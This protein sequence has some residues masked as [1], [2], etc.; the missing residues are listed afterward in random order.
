M[1]SKERTRREPQERAVRTRA[2]ILRA[3]AEVFDEFGFSGASISK[4][5]KRAG[6]TQGAMYFHFGSK[7]ELAHAVMIGQG[8]GLHMPEG[9]DGLQRLI[10]ITLYLARQ[11]QTNPVLRGG[12]RLAVEQGEFGMHDDQP[13]QQ[14]VEV[15]RQQLQAARARG[16]LNEAADE[17]ELAVVLVGSFSGTQL[18]SQI[19]TGRAD[20]PELICTLWRY[21]LPAAATEEARASFRIAPDAADV[22]DAPDALPLSD[23]ATP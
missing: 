20:L 3:A 9:E 19:T 17:G 22:P 4:I 2:V 14:W 18:F 7:E 8:E 6:V 15:F 12:V 16:E 13:Y 21:L 10:D 23:A 1:S 11:L 5:M